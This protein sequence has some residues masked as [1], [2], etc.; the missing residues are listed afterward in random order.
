MEI[1]NSALVMHVE[2]PRHKNGGIIKLPSNVKCT[3]SSYH[4]DIFKD[5]AEED[6]EHMA[7]IVEYCATMIAKKHEDVDV[8]I[9]YPQD[10]KTRVPQLYQVYFSF[11][12]GTKISDRHFNQ[13]KSYAFR[14]ITEPMEVDY[15]PVTKLQRLRVLINPMACLPQ[16]EDMTLTTIHLK[17]NRVN[18]VYDNATPD[19]DRGSIKRPRTR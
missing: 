4:G 6:R 2:S 1:N 13:M 15:D 5:V 12:L 9:F 18:V 7:L 17:N 16:F 19:D 8:I 14:K 3:D 10:G 11:P